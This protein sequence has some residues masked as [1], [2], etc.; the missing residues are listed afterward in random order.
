MSIALLVIFV[1]F[2]I[3][4]LMGIPIGFVLGIVPVI[5]LK[6]FGNIP[7]D[8]I[9]QRLFNG[10]D[11]FVFLAMP[12]FILAG[13]LMNDIGI[14]NSLV[15]LSKVIVGRI[16]GGLAQANIVVSV[17][18]A[19][20]TGAAVAD[21]AAIGSMLVPA[22]KKEGYSAEYSA[23]VT[24]SSSIIGPIIPPSIIMVIYG[25]VTGQS[26]GAL[27]MAGFLPGILVAICLMLLA[28][29]F[30]IK[31]GHPRRSEAYTVREILTTI[32]SSLVAL[33]VPIIIIGGILSGLFTATEAAAVACAYSLFVGLFV[34]KNLTLKKIVEALKDSA[35][36]SASI[37][38]IVGCSKLFSLALAIEHVPE[39]IATTVT[40]L[41]DNKI[42]FLLVINIFLLFMGMVMEIGASVILLAPILLPLAIQYGIHPLHF[43]LIMLVNLNIGLATPP[44][45]VC[46][47]TIAPIAKTPFE[48]IVPK[49]LP[50]IGA[51]IV[52]LFLIT[53]I[54]DI[55]LLIPRLAGYL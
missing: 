39:Q 50:F 22:M 8:I 12:F 37:L 24:A 38:I 15:K 31:E 46:I 55:V 23:A 10:V 40:A 13:N 1:V 26:I 52:A 49:L 29:Y 34:Y 7:L 18:F 51:E 54:P 4:V 2:L 21:T 11:S 20:L 17:L 35:I 44:L 5:Y 32:R 25:A 6:F 3:T 43:A 19:G 36:V 28:T 47:F 9:A 48:K 33:L 30:A 14:T 42:V 16:H 41:I 45:G 53:Y 27:F